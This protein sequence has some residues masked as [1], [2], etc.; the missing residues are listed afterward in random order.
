[1]KENL[2]PP[3]TLFELSIKQY[4]KTGHYLYRLG[5]LFQDRLDSSAACVREVTHLKM[6][7]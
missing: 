3:E 1:M 6:Y 5:P 4:K 7:S 2:F